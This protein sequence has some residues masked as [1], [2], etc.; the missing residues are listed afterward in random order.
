MASEHNIVRLVYCVTWQ[1]IVQ[2]APVDHTGAYNLLMPEKRVYRI[3][4]LWKVCLAFPH[5]HETC[6]SQLN[7][8]LHLMLCL[9]R[10]LVCIKYNYLNSLSFSICPDLSSFSSSDESMPHHTLPPTLQS[11]DKLGVLFFWTFP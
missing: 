4:S 8:L 5:L 1:E 11:M 7:L 2:V 6:M 10:F 9:P 3:I